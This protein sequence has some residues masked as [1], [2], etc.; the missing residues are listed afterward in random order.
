MSNGEIISKE[1]GR[2]MIQ[3]FVVT[4]PTA[5]KAHAFDKNLIMELLDSP[6]AEGMRIYYAYENGA[7]CVVLVAIDAHGD[8]LEDNPVIERG[9][10]CPPYCT[11]NVYFLD[12]PIT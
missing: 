10:P 11:R 3:N 8:D 7:P 4:H 9:K 12:G 6:G 1:I 5:I 2:E